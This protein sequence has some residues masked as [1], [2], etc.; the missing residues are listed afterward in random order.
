MIDFDRAD[1]VIMASK[2][3][4]LVGMFIKQGVN[5]YS[6]MLSGSQITLDCGDLQCIN[7]MSER[8]RQEER[9]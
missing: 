2:N 4:E 3:Y 8:L 9:F 1:E 6:F 7:N 5:K